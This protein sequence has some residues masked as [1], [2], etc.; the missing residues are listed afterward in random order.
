MSQRQTLIH[1]INMMTT[2]YIQV[3]TVHTVSVYDMCGT[4]Y[5]L[6]LWHGS[7]TE[8]LLGFFKI[9]LENLFVEELL[10]ECSV[11]DYNKVSKSD[12]FD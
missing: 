8:S 11:K 3:Y 7:R 4:N 5:R 10:Q 9:C 12:P 1:S 2:E 6:L